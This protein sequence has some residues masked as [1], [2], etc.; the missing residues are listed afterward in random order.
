MIVHHAGFV[1]NCEWV[2]CCITVGSVTPSLVHVV[3]P[4]GGNTGEGGEE[5]HQMD[6]EL[7]DY[8]FMTE[9]C[10]WLIRLGRPPYCMRKMK[11]VYRPAT[12]LHF[13]YEIAVPI[14]WSPQRSWWGMVLAKTRPAQWMTSHN[15]YRPFL[16][17]CSSL[18]VHAVAR[19]PDLTSFAAF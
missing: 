16:G 19:L 18:V 9:T 8:I 4:T 5:E 15:N 11:K 2:Y 7:V 1:W 10:Q 13:V 6:E 17:K 3:G 12:W 14:F